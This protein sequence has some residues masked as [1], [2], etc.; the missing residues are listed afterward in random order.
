MDVP[1]E[2]SNYEKSLLTALKSFQENYRHLT[3]FTI[4]CQNG[5]EFNS[6]KILLAARSKYFE[7]LFRQ[8]P[9]KSSVKLDFDDHVV[10]TV[11]KSLV[12]SD[13]NEFL[14]EDLLQLLEVTDFLQMEDYILEI[15]SAMSKKLTLENIYDVMEF[16]ECVQSLSSNFGMHCSQFVKENLLNFDLN[17]IPKTWL[18]AL[19]LASS[20]HVKD[21]EGRFLDLLESEVKLAAILHRI[22]PEEPW[23]F[24]ME[25]KRKICF[26]LYD[27]SLQD[28]FEDPNGFNQVILGLNYNS[29]IKYNSYRP[30]GRT[31]GL[32]SSDSISDR[33]E[34]MDVLKQKY[35]QPGTDILI[36]FSKKGHFFPNTDFIFQFFSVFFQM[37][38][39]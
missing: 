37:M 39:C 29:F 5:T 8:E 31:Y 9:Q 18:K 15:M 36:Y 16:S 7:A 17:K 32:A 3:D 13:F 20:C 30:R 12:C 19:P 35:F 1:K 24:S 28:I 14:V 33:K 25:S 34:T 2:I 21:L 11:L 10:E 23:Q 4:I 22:D 38:S 27:L 26:G 6:H